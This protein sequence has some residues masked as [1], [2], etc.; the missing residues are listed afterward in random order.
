MSVFVPLHVYGCVSP[1][2]ETIWS[3][4]NGYMHHRPI[5]RETGDRLI[6]CRMS[7]EKRQDGERGLGIRDKESPKNEL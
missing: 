4:V 5:T 6:L 1:V 3:S 7:T 2:C